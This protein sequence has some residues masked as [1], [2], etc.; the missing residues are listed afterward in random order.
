MTT[1]EPTSAP[2]RFRSLRKITLTQWILISMV[3]GIAL[4]W[5]F[6]QASQN[7]QIVSTIFLRMIKCILVPLVFAML[8][9]GIA[10]HSDDLKAIGRLALRAIIYFELVTTL[11]LAVG[12][13]AVNFAQPGVG[14]T[15]PARGH[16]TE[17]L[18]P[19]QVTLQGVIEHL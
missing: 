15:L 8:V 11:A 2:P 13:I 14:V 10:G 17:G 16:G 19:T 4:G 12:L 9:V 6:P 1:P 5:I 18:A 3:L 7:L